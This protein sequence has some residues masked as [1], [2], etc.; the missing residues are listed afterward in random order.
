MSRG[1][2]PPASSS[3]DQLVPTKSEY[4][5]NLWI[6]PR[7]FA[8]QPKVRVA[9]DTYVTFN[10]GKATVENAEHEELIRDALRNLR[11]RVFDEDSPK[12]FVIKHIGWVTYSS[13][14]FQVAND[15]LPRS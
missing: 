11:I 8:A 5:K 4:P 15:R 9:K 1:N 7:P 6:L 13:E 12:P 14:A 10:N 2:T 3:K